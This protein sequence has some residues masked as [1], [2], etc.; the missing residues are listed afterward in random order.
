M[1][2]V[3]GRKLLTDL[4]ISSAYERLDSHLGLSTKSGMFL[5][6]GTALFWIFLIITGSN[7]SSELTGTFSRLEFRVN[8]T[9]QQ[10]SETE[11]KCP[12]QGYSLAGEPVNY[13]FYVLNL[14]TEYGAY[15]S[16]VLATGRF[17]KSAASDY[18]A[19]LRIDNVQAFSEASGID[20]V[21]QNLRGRLPNLV[22][23][24]TGEGTKLL[25]GL[26]LGDD[27]AVSE[28]LRS[29]M[30]YT[31]LSHLTAV[32]GA[33]CSVIV[34]LLHILF[35]GLG[36]TIA[37]LLAITG[38]AGFVVL[39]GA[40]PSVQRAAAMA[41]IVL[42]GLVGGKRVKAIAAL[43]LACLILLLIE[44]WLAT[45][46]GFSLSTSATAA[47]ILFQ[48]AITK[49]LGKHMPQKLALLLSVPIAAQI[50]A[51][52]VLLMLDD[53]ISLVSIPANLFAAPL[54][55]VAT[56]IGLLA[57]SLSFISEPVASILAII[58]WVPAEII[59]R[60]SFFFAWLRSEYDF[61]TL[62][63]MGGI[64][65][66][67]ALGIFLVSLL[68]KNRFF[69]FIKA[70]SG[71]CLA[72]VLSAGI[73]GVA[74]TAIA[75]AGDW[76][77]A[78]CDVGQGDAV[79]IR[80]QGKVL[81]YDTGES[82][83]KLTEC[84]QALRIEK[85]DLVAV[86]HFDKD[87]VGGLLALSGNVERILSAKSSQENFQ[88]FE[89]L[90]KSGAKY[91][92]L[93]FGDSFSFGDFDVQVIYPRRVEGDGGNNESLV[94][95]FQGPFRILLL[96]DLGKTGQEEIMRLGIIEN[97]DVL[98]IAHHGSKD[99][100]EKLN[101]RLAPKIALI[102]VGAGNTYGHPTIELLDSLRNSADSWVVRTDLHGLSLIYWRE[103]TMHV[104]TAR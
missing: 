40:E 54:A 42:I 85:L 96:G 7:T 83:E 38:L 39:V 61:L 25:P 27:S 55:P 14:A 66:A 81:L 98:K 65:T 78:Q 74:R 67:I 32:S 72:V 70:A 16:K 56:V 73:M 69:Q 89:P 12:V 101:T 84:L 88:V 75:G 5:V 52:P 53:G 4:S 100:S 99:F 34:V 63:L 11:A 57:L 102:G 51:Q 94:L 79:I 35:S 8:G 64:F 87:H 33:N 46:V 95:Y 20:T 90:I 47:L 76:V 91:S 30:I 18:H 24:M 50:G 19:L 59:S 104:W 23:K 71:L 10:V 60:I 44:P 82:P 86:S 13:R 37:N 43:A 2:R 58:A 68:S 49:F 62:P 17:I 28:R 36:R 31:S 93:S 77:I 80:S 6:A 21:V 9:C 103:L 22:E 3:S 41:V 1:S 97:I 15:G 45:S 92:E 29:D 26:V 48:P